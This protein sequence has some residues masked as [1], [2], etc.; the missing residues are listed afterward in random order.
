A[1]TIPPRHRRITLAFTALSLSVPER[2]RFRYWL[3]GF[4][5]DWSDPVSARQAVYTNLGPGPYRFRVIASNSDGAWNSA[6]A[7]LAFTIAPALWETRWF[8]GSTALL[9]TG[10]AW[11]AY[12]LRRTHG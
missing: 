7:A 6:E 12:P 3:D 4:D 2:V 1:L 5:H 10:V 8:Q 11:G 9:L